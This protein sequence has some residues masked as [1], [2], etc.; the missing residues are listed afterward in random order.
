MRTKRWYTVFGLLLFLLLCLVPGGEAQQG[1]PVPYSSNPAQLALSWT[2][3]STSPATAAFNVSGLRFWQLNFIPIGTVS[4][5]SVSVD[6]STGSGSGFSVGG[7][8]AS[9][10]IGSCASAATYANS[11]ATT[12]TLL[13]QLTPTITGSGSVVVVLLGYANN[14]GAAGSSSATIVGPVDG[15]GNVKINCVTGCSGTTLGQ[16]T[17]ALSL[18]VAIASNQSAVPVTTQP[19]GFGS[20]PLTGQVAVTASAVALASNAAHVVCITALITNTIP[21]YAGATGVTT[22]T[23]FPLNAGDFYCWQVSNSNLLF[24]IASTTG[25]SIAWTAL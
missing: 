25:A 2:L 22:G 9:G 23:G 24:L 19:S 13:G 20:S 21:V 15:S 11:S 4:A 12:P 18:P 5:C 16:A 8:L 6:S 1:T 17:M 7:I 14:P 10:T 3:N